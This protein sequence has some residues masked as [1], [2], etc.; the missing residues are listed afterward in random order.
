[1]ALR[2]ERI[3]QVRADEAA[4]AGN[5][6]V[7]QCRLLRGDRLAAKLAISIK[8]SDCHYEIWIEHTASAHGNQTD[9]AIKNLHSTTVNIL[10]SADTDMQCTP[11]TIC[12]TDNEHEM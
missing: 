5:E 4:A 11:H 1:V 9:L 12:V 10:S 3:G 6:E 8:Y 2:N 7:R